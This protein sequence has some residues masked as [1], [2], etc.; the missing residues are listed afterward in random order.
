M[1]AAT[2]LGDEAARAANLE[3]T[4]ATLRASQDPYVKLAVALSAEL[5]EQRTRRRQTAGAMLRVR[6]Y[7]L[8]AMAAMRAAEGRAIYPDANGTLRISFATVKGYVPREGLIATPQTSVLGLVEKE[9]GREPF[10]SPGKVLAAVRAEDWG[11]WA[12]PRL[13]A[14]PIDFLSDA[15]T[16][17]GNSGSPVVNGRG[18]LVGL[19]FDRVWENVAGDFGWNAERSRN[20][21]LDIR[22]ALWLIDRVDGAGELLRE[23]TESAAGRTR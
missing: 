4:L 2:A 20:V 15:D 19:N 16:T 3:A 14:V 12:D 7:L 1:D 22:Y 23:L 18:E 10:A 9:T 11:R 6:P 21:N 17:G 13:A 5:G 8:T